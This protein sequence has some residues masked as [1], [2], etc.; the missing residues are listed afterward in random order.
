MPFDMPCTKVFPQ[1]ARICCFAR[2]D[3]A[4]LPRLTDALALAGDVTA[5]VVVELDVRVLAKMRPDL[6]IAD[7]DHLATDPLEVLRQ[8]RFVLPT[9]VIAIVS[10]D[11]RRAW[12]LDAHMAGA[13]AVLSLQ[14]TDDDL[15]AGINDA[16]MNGCFTDPRF[17]A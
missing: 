12:A 2:I 8:I 3:P 15:A 14:A 9:C 6:L 1:M 4:V 11:D 16:V 10:N 17:V 5:P 7:V 13:N